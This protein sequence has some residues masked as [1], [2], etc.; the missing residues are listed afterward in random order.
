MNTKKEDEVRQNVKQT[1]RLGSLSNPRDLSLG[2]T[3]QK[4]VYMPNI[5]AIRSKNKTK[6]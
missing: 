6:E 2:G 1:N 5:N 4:K 3:K